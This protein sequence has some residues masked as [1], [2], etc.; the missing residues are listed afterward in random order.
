MLFYG[1]FGVDYITKF[2][3]NKSF[4]CND[5]INDKEFS[6]LFLLKWSVGKKGDCTYRHI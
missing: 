2:Y 4:V 1:I 3:K 6:K 5:S